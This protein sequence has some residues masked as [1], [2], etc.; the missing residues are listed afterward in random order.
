MFVSTLERPV[1]VKD[2]AVLVEIVITGSVRRELSNDVQM[3]EQGC[4]PG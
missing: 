1:L 4:A 2:T 3:E